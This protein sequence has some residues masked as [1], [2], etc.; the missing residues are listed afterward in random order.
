MDITWS[1]GGLNLNLV[2]TAGGVYHTGRIEKERGKDSAP[3]VAGVEGQEFCT[4]VFR[5]DGVL[6][7]ICEEKGIIEEI[8]LSAQC[9][10]WEA[11]ERIRMT[12]DGK[13]FRTQRYHMLEDWEGWIA[14]CF[15]LLR[16]DGAYTYPLQCYGVSPEQVECVRCDVSWAVPLPVHFYSF[17]DISMAYG[18]DRRTGRGTPNAFAGENGKRFLGVYLPDMTEQTTDNAAF[19]DSHRPD[20]QLFHKGEE[21]VVSEFL[22]AV[23]LHEG[24]LPLLEGEKIAAQVLLSQPPEMEPLEVLAERFAFYFTHNQLWEDNVFAPGRGWY[25]N[26]WTHTHGGVPKKDPYYDLGWGEGYGVLT[27][28]ALARYHQRK[29]AGFEKEIR[30]LTE[31]MVYFLRDLQVPGGYYDRYVPEGVPSLLGRDVPGCRG[32]F[33]GLPK[34]WTHC[35]AQVGLQLVQLYQDLPDYPEQDLRNSWLKTAKDIAA[36]FFARR[37]ENGDVQDGF[38]LE[39]QE[40]NHKPHRIPAR[41]A[42][43]GLWARMGEIEGKQ[44]YV[45]AALALARAAAPHACDCP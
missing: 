12:E 11:V 20:S 33:L 17:E 10:Q 27:L 29:G 44:D 34:I 42:L 40:C 25:R 32:D 41:A 14:P 19:V 31:N 1:M 8:T 24:Q 37:K 38:D 16:S 21:W 36:F 7:E 18:V 4:S 28:S 13:W 43:C 2:E 23:Q 6:T 39:D 5:C 3:L 9:P 30:Q 22:G 26:M 15:E 35:L 45:D